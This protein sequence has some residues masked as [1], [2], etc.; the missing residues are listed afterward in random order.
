[1]GATG[2]QGSSVVEALLKDGKWDVRAMSRD[3]EK[4]QAKELKKKG[5]EVVKGD[6]KNESELRNAMKGIHAIFALTAFWDPDTMFKEQELGKKIV[7]ISKE[8]GVKHFIWSSLPNVAKISNNKYHVPH[9]TDKAIVAEYAQEKGLFCTFVAPA[10]YYQNFATFFP[11]KNENGTMIFS[12]PMPESKKLTAFDV[13]DTG[14]AVVTALNNPQEWKD[15]F[16]AL[17]GD[18]MHPQDYISTYTKVTG[19][20]AKYVA[21]PTDV[22]AKYPFPGAKEVAEMFAWFNEFTY[23]GPH[24]FTIGK[25]ANPNLKT[26]EQ[27]LKVSGWKG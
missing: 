9:F 20:P 16:I 23:F 3:P 6:M 2:A 18:H 8:S 24:D 1:L 17:A 5:V 12:M 25:K 11:P 22:W 4:E 27:Y 15:K 21:V 13:A 14:A 26:W 19:I 7:D 10:F